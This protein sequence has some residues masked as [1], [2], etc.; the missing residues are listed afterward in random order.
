MFELQPCSSVLE[1]SVIHIQLVCIEENLT[2]DLD[3]DL[4]RADGGKQK[5]NYET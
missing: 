1:K 2:L 4:G 5:K 3:L